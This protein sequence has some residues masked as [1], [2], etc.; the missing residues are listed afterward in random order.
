[1]KKFAV[2][3]VPNKHIFF[4]FLIDRFLQTGNISTENSRIFVV[5]STGKHSK[6]KH[7]RGKYIES[8][9]FFLRVLTLSIH[10]HC[11]HSKDDR[12]NRIEVQNAVISVFDLHDHGLQL[13]PQRNL[14]F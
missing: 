1:M 5:E 13:L 6:K 12:D 7:R 11:D 2:A 4:D 3:S 10:K 9:E 14:L 8:E